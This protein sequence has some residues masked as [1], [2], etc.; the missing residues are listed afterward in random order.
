MPNTRNIRK[1]AQSQLNDVTGAAK[2]TVSDLTAKAAE[3]VNELLAQAEKAV[4]V[5]AIKAA[6]E[7][8]VAQARGYST[9][10]TDRAEELYSTVKND[11]RVAKLVNTAESV[12]GV[13][14]ETVQDRVVKPAQ[15]LTGRGTKRA[16]AQPRKPAAKA[17]AAKK[18]ATT[19]A[20]PKPVKTTARPATKASAKSTASKS[21]ARKTPA[22]KATK[23][24][25]ATKA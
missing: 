1:Q 20:A 12:T 23:A 5:D 19:K 9:T 25:K 18:T 17:P 21:T 7:P 3:A 24:T 8:Y 22:K 6:I 11:D 13:V 2:D 15:A 10:V 4:N 14:V 16:K